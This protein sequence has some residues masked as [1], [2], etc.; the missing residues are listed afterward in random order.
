M[1]EDKY[2]GKGGTII[3]GT[4]NFDELYKSAGYIKIGDSLIVTIEKYPNRLHRFFMKLFFGWEFVRLK[5]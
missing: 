2:L 3:G 4:I 5:K 1:N